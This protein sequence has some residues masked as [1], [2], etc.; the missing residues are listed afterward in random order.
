[1]DYQSMTVSE[2]RNLAK[3]WGVSIPKNA[4]KDYIIGVLVANEPVEV[5]AEVITEAESGS[6]AV[7]F[8]AGEITANFDALEARVDAILADYED[9]EPTANSKD[10]VEQC[11][12]H[13][14]YLNGL[15]KQL[16]ERRKAVKQQYLQPL[17]AFE[18]RANSIRDKIK[19]VSER[20]K[21]VE[22]DAD[23]FRRAEKKQALSEHYEAYAGLLLDLV[24]YS[25]LH[26]ERWLNKTF[27]M[28]KAQD[29][30][31][32]KVDQL[33]RD[34]EMLKSL[35]LEFQA[36][37]EAMLFDTLDAAKAISWARKL[38]DD[39]RK[40]EAMTDEMGEPAPEPIPAP[41]PKP[42]PNQAPMEGKAKVIADIASMLD[43]YP[44]QKLENLRDAIA[45]SRIATGEPEPC[46]MVI[47]GATVA[48]ME[49]VG[50]FCG[51]AGITGVF[52]RGTLRDVFER[53]GYG[54]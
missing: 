20:L 30:L 47:D 49:L 7:T 8:N 3:E 31:E 28:A 41:I 37:A 27:A 15:A 50:K 54:M 38:A 6:L 2:L 32:S 46:V 36:D 10:D 21:A 19:A 34:W 23:A 52:K 18:S 16:D 40:L 35:D 12:H 1:M 25:K 24:P 9:W 13:R 5:E 48:Q 22:D 45:K 14:K 26:D 4:K 44:Q 43:W 53:S 33:A 29:E 39:K 11:A 17:N 51:L 42:V